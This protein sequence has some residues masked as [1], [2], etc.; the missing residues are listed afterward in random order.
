MDNFEY[1]IKVD[2]EVLRQF[3]VAEQFT[4]HHKAEVEK[5]L[6]IVLIKHYSKHFNLFDDLRQFAWTAIL[7]RRH[8][9]DYDPTR[10]PYNYIY[11]TFRNEVGNN[12]IKLLKES[13]VEDII[14]LKESVHNAAVDELPSEIVKYTKHLTGEE[15]YTYLRI[16]KKDVLPLVL[17]VRLFEK[18][19]EVKVPSFLSDYKN[20]TQVLFKLLK[21]MFDE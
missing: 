1:K 11:T 17:F 2:K 7:E 20:S 6:N 13:S 18:K 9:K 3:F 14:N 8:R 15:S 4:D 21:E 19:R 10:C 12:I 5:V 16:P